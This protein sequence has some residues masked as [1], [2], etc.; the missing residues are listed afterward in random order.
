MIDIRYISSL[1]KTALAGH[2]E[3]R[4]PLRGK[5][6]IRF[7]EWVGCKIRSD[8]SPPK[9]LSHRQCGAAP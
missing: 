9:F 5:H 6:K 3:Q 1:D 8:T 2:Y 4:F 7:Q